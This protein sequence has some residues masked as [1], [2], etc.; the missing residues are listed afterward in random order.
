VIEERT[1]K[2]SPN[3]KDPNRTQNREYESWTGTELSTI[4]HH[5]SDVKSVVKLSMT[6]SE[7]STTD[8]QLEVHLKGGGYNYDSTS[9]RR[10]FYA[11]ESQL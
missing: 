7:R 9:I 3:P 8:W 5:G 1:V 10:P 4:K 2:K 11:V 6:D